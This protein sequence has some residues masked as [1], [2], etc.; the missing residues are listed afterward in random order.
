[1]N[2]CFESFEIEGNIC[3]YANSM[4]RAGC[5]SIG[6]CVCVC[7]CMCICMCIC[8]YMCIYVSICVYMCVCVY[9]FSQ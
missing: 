5:S 1:M 7:I 6:V 8:V 3:S 2:M 4:L 9:I